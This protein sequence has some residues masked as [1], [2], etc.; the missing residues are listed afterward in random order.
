MTFDHCNYSLDIPMFPEDA[1]DIIAKYIEKHKDEFLEW[2]MPLALGKNKIPAR[3]YPDFRW[4]PESL[5]DD[6]SGKRKWDLIIKDN[7]PDLK[8]K[9]VCDLGCNI[10]IFSLEMA[11]LGARRV[12]GFDRGLDI[13]QPNNIN[14]GK[15]SVAQQAYF[16]RNLYEI[17]HGERFPQV[18]FHEADLMTLDISHDHYDVMFACCVLYHLGAPRMEEIIKMASEHIPEIFLQA[19]NGHGGGLGL[20]SS[21]DHHVELLEKYGYEIVRIDKGPSGYPHPIVYG[22]KQ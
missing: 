2:Y 4:R 6:T 1:E 18:A 14:L 10:G 8:G 19:N 22:R 13:V 5:A 7:L 11:R 3:T 16:V 12:E 9:V 21:L 20:L 15:Q 17:Y